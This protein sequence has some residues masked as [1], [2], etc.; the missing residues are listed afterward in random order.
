MKSFVRTAVGPLILHSKLNVCSWCQSIL[1]TRAV[2]V[3]SAKS[4]YW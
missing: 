4:Y 3:A 2:F 1:N